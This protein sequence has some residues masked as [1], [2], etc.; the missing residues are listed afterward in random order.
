M[1]PHDS[2]L[3]DALE[4]RTTEVFLGG[5]WRVTRA[6]RDALMGSTAPGRWSPGEDREVMT[7]NEMIEAFELG[8]LQPSPGLFDRDK[9][10]WMNGA[11]IRALPPDGLARIVRD[12]A[13][14]NET[15]TYWMNVEPEPGKPDPDSVRASLVKL[16]HAFGDDSEYAAAAMALAQERVQTLADFGLACDFFF[17]EQPAMDAKAVE[18]WFPLPPVRQLFAELSAW[19]G[20][21][22]REA[23]ADTC[24]AWVRAFAE[25]NGMEKLGPTVHPIR[26]ALTGRTFGPG[27]F[28]LMSLLGP[29]RMIARLDRARS[30]L[31]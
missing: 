4:G 15:A 22:G 23:S 5:V 8:G 18:K 25:T 28:E 10:D 19:L 20:T 24:E 2:A 21:V 16:G 30:L 6:G 9:L 27:L 12:Y 31:P 11:A 13:S 7:R 1:R 29:A 3:I 17:A 14:S 26:V